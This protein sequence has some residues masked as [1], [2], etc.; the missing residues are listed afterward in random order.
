ML[1]VLF[2]NGSVV[3]L[4]INHRSKV[5]QIEALSG[6]GRM[7]ILNRGFYSMKCFMEFPDR[8]EGLK[9]ESQFKRKPII[10]Y[11][12][13]EAGQYKPACPD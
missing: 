5:K 8:R 9:S 11:Y 7:L 1:A 13:N 6:K 3:D 4:W 12:C 10:C 2:E